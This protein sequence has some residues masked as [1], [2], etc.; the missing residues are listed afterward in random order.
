MRSR[1]WHPPFPRAHTWYQSS[2]VAWE[3]A[4]P[5]T[6][7][8]WWWWWRAVGRMARCLCPTAAD[9]CTSFLNKNIFQLGRNLE[10]STSP[11]PIKSENENIWRWS[12]KPSA[13]SNNHTNSN[14][15]KTYLLPVPYGEIHPLCRSMLSDSKIEFKSDLAFGAVLSC[16]QLSRAGVYISVQK[17]YSPP[18]MIFFPLSRNV[19][20][21]LLLWPFC[22]ISPYFA[23]IFSCYF[24]FSLFLSPFIYF[25]SSFFLFLLHFSPFSLPLFIFFPPNY[26]G[27]Y[28]TVEGGGDIP[29]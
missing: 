24:P 15:K 1:Q 26:I 22:L 27:W 2:A 6:R 28:S 13:V 11:S 16:F 3:S 25:L 9:T 10:K 20:F 17:R 4:W 21:R 12:L 19:V 18:P 23:F 14:E 7:A 29:I 8:W 5:G